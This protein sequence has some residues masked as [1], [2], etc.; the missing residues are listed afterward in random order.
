MRALRGK[1]LPSA[2]RQRLPRL[3]F[4]QLCFLHRRA[5]A[6]PAVP[7]PNFDVTAAPLTYA[8]SGVMLDGYGFDGQTVVAS[9]TVDPGLYTHVVGDGST[10]AQGVWRQLG[11]P[12]AH[13]RDDLAVRRLRD[14]VG[15]PKCAIPSAEAYVY[16]N[17]VGMDEFIVDGSTDLNTTTTDFSSSVR[18]TTSAIRY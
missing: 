5:G 3:T 4:E 13:S 16:K 1:D 17:H 18:R 10:W 14:D 7:A 2:S 15:R 6:A 9:L 11:W 12:K 8:F